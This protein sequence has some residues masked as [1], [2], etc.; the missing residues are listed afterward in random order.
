LSRFRNVY[1]ERLQPLYTAR[2]EP[3]P[4]DNHHHHR[5]QQRPM[6]A[7][8]HRSG[9]DPSLQARFNAA[10][11]AASYHDLEDLLRSD[12]H[13]ININAFDPA[14]GQTALQRFCVAGEL[15]LIQLMVRYG[16]D[17]RLCSR[18][19]W[20]PVHM[21]AWSGRPEVMLYVMDCSKRC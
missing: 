4:P 17:S 1:E 8:T 16:A 14:T 13:R 15:S 12:A 3:P 2:T 10:V 7:A 21:A 20:S 11:A 6:P 18:D 19:G 9:V 5:Q